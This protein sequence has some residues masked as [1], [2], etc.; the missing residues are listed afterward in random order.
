MA[1]LEDI[2]RTI[3][4]LAPEEVQRLRAWIEELEEQLF[5]ERIERDVLAGKFDA[6]ADKALADH[7]AG[8]S[9]KL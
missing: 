6:L 7:L 1:T 8:K 9:R 2:K 4:A 5:D 3:A